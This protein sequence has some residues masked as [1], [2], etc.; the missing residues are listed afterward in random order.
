M[1]P[2][3]SLL[4]TFVALACAQIGLPSSA[5]AEYTAP[6]S[7]V[8]SVRGL[9]LGSGVRAS[10][11]GTHAQAD[12]PANIVRGG[13]YH[14]EAFVQHDTANKLTGLGGAVV[15]CMTS[16]LAAGFS[17]RGLVGDN[18]AGKHKGFDGRLSLAYPL[19]EAF[20]LGVALRYADLRVA[21]PDA[22]EQDPDPDPDAINRRYKLKHFTMDVAAT[23]QIDAL[24]VSALAYNLVETDSLLAPRQVGGSLS[25]GATEALTIGGDVLVDLDSFEASKV[26]AGGGLEFLMADSF[27]LRGGYLYDQGRDRHGVTAGLGY[28]DKTVGLQAGLRQFVGSEPDTNLMFVL[29]YFVR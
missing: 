11:M 20:S 3:R 22:F 16:K 12:N 21:Y 25:L 10:A 27:P 6:V 7:R 24:S 18:E 4:A 5:R 28:V 19:V 14:L 1:V 23:L 8:E 9:A 2:F 17:M 15:D 29:Q 26:L 13:L